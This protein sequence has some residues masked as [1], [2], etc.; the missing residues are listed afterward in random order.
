M[1]DNQYLQKFEEWVSGLPDNVIRCRN[2]RHRFADWEDKKARARGVLGWVQIEVP[3]LRGCK[4]TLTQFIDP[5][6]GYIARSNRIKYDYDSKYIMPPEVRS[7]RGI[8]REMNAV[9]RAERIARLF[10]AGRVEKEE[11]G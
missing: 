2:G 11:D 5:D 10:N 4:T 3:C 1:A 9:F 7:G 8:T 6:T